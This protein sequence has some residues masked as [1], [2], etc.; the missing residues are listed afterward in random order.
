MAYRVA[1]PKNKENFAQ[2]AESLGGV[3]LP[4]NTGNTG[5]TGNGPIEHTV[6][7][8]TEG[9]TLKKLLSTSSEPKPA[10]GQEEAA[11]DRE[12]DRSAGACWNCGVAWSDVVT[13]I[14]GRRWKVCWSC[15]KTA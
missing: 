3:P 1:L 11:E 9:R 13:D 5:N 6:A 14:Y 12:E 8:P 2:E 7:D 10:E 15:S 4:K